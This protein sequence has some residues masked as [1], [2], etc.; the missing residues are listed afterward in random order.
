MPR[1]IQTPEKVFALLKQCV[2]KLNQVKV[3]QEGML[4]PFKGSFEGPYVECMRRAAKAG[5]RP[6]TGVHP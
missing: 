6:R 3:E 5:V 1:P 4:H 2:A